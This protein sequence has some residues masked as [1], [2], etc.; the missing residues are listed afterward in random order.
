MDL[1][2]IANVVFGLRVGQ[3]KYNDTLLATLVT[4]LAKEAGCEQIGWT[5]DGQADFSAP[6]ELG[7]YEK[8]QAERLRR[9]LP[10]PAIGGI[11]GSTVIVVTQDS[12][13]DVAQAVASM[14]TYLSI[15][16]DPKVYKETGQVVVTAQLD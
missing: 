9:E 10:A 14:Y 12:V 6:P 1:Y 5:V 4:P 11:I 2:E 8:V 7:E 13:Q 16:G 3:P 15:D